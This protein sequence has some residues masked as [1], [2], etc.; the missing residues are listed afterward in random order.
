[1]N[2]IRNLVFIILGIVATLIIDYVMIDYPTFVWIF[3]ALMFIVI[4]VF[5]QLYIQR[6]KTKKIVWLTHKLDDTKD[7]LSRKDIVEKRI[8]NDLPIGIIIY[9]Q[10]YNIKWANGYSKDIFENVLEQRTLEMVNTDIYDHLVGKYHEDTFVTKVYTHEYEVEIDR[11]ERIIYLTQVTEREELKRRYEASVGV[12]AMLN[13][14]NLDDAIS[15]LDVSNRSFVQG[16]YLEVLEAWGEEYSF[17]ITPLTNSKLIAVMNKQ[18]LM[19][20]VKNEF[21][22]VETVA[23]ISREYGILVTLSA[24]IACSNIKLNKLGDIANDALDL[25]LSR[26]G[27]QIVVNIEGNDLMYF[28]GNTNTAE[29]RTRITTRTNTQKLERL[30]EEK[31]RVF[32]MPHHHPDTDAFGAAIGVLKL[33]QAYNKDAK[34]IINRDDL[35]KTV[36]KILQ[37]MEYE[38]ITF[39]DYI[40]T[41]AKALETI[42]K[43]DLLIL[44]DHHSYS[45]NMDSKI[46]GKTKNLV[47]IDHHRKLNDAI[48]GAL[49]S[50]IEPYASSSVELVTEMIDLT[51]KD[52]ELNNFEATVMLSGIIVDTN[53]FM[54]RTGSRT[55]E[56]SAYLRKYGADTFKVKTILRPGLEEIQLKSQLLTLAEV[57]HKRFSI[58]I[59]PRDLNPTRTL[60]AKVADDLLEIEDTVASFAIGYLGPQTV[61]IS[62]RS[63]EGFNVQVVMEKFNGGGHLN[64]A[65][66]QIETDDI[67]QVRLDLIQI[68]NET[69]SEEKPMKVI[70]IKDL[71]GKGKKGQVIEVATGYGNYLLSSKIAIEATQQNLH[72]IELEKAKQEEVERKTLEEMKAL[73]EK[74][75][76]LPVKVF[77]KIGENGKLFGKVNSKQIAM[78]FKKQHKLTIDK[79]KIDLKQNIAS[80]GNYK[81]EVKL[82]KN[83][84]ATIE[85][86]VVEE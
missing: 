86:L 53:N 76:K 23:E 42:T 55:F 6:K 84:T 33:A 9:D 16:R 32:I 30:F 43:E 69:V 41:P 1:M 25:A 65:G 79:R 71:K 77:V 47:I 3:S 15:V 13:L 67:K 8:A 48:D 63:L 46:V 24:G 44:V 31:Q 39:L 27:D 57:I 14:D 10:R 62:A 82:H 85:V 74:I 21:K 68:L 64:N 26:G 70:L 4:N 59:I 60:L 34:I 29:K 19:N 73:K 56:A 38:Y 81:V 58:V 12:I 78:E 51:T 80:L 17:Y 35:D 37:M 36:F 75:E 11:D 83:V 61:G 72:S 66:A 28:G 7:T 54:Y 45:Q 52:V 5:I 2:D 50:H 22:I 18:T 40:I 20:L 49:I